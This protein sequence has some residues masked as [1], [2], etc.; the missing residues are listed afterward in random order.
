MVILGD[1][2]GSKVIPGGILLPKISSATFVDFRIHNIG[3]PWITMDSR[4][5]PA[6]APE[7]FQFFHQ[8]STA[9]GGDPVWITPNFGNPDF[10]GFPQKPEFTRDPW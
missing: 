7:I 4:R 9:I 8:I 2:W 10:R 5:K 3:F 1:P 6:I